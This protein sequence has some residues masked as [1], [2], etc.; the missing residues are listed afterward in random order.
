MKCLAFAMEKEAKPVLEA[1]Q[2]LTKRSYGYSTIYKC[3]KGKLDFFVGISGIG[4]G[5]A[6]AFVSALCLSHPEVD[7]IV[8]VGVGGSLDAEKAPLLSAVIASS[9]VQ[10]DL[11][12]S[13][14]GDPVGLISGINLV[15]IPA[16][17][18]INAP[19]ELA[20]K[21]LGIPY[22]FGVISSGDKFI[23]DPKKKE[24]IREK[25]ASLSVDMESA[26]MAQIAY[27][28][29]K[30]FSALRVVSDTGDGKEYDANVLKAAELASK[31]I[32]FL[33]EN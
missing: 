5:F 28:F 8:N 19:L 3:R 4:K 32:F 11:D 12:T 10:H 23:V 13:E 29:N 21:S 7:T 22:S 14:I 18:E 30:K 2:I 31:I 24:K 33:L 25:F 17:K 1:S 15:T 20:C 9:F 6:A 26:P 16:S 27:C